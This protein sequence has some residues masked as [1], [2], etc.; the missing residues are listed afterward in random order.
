MRI[1]VKAGDQFERYE[2]TLWQHRGCHRRT[3]GID[4]YS[5][6]NI[7]L[8][9]ELPLMRRDQALS[10]IRAYGHEVVEEAEPFPRP[11]HAAVTSDGLIAYLG[12]EEGCRGISRHYTIVPI[13][14]WWG[15][16]R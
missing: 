15:G 3:I 9:A 13:G 6:W 7:A 11:T 8:P 10:I 16:G 12:S 5:P 2:N 1:D 4:G 14:H